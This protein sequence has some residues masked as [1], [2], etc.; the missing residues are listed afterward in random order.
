MGWPWFIPCFHLPQPSMLAPPTK[1]VLPRSEAD[2]TLGSCA[3][4]LDVEV[5]LG[6]TTDESVPILVSQ[7]EAG[8]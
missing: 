4:P 8:S 3:L 1:F 5:T 6:W 7:A 2:F